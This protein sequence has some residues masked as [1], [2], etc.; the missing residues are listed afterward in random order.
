MGFHSG[1]LS[2]GYLGVDVFFA[3]SGFLITSLLVEEYERNGAISLRKF[4][5]RRALRLLPALVVLIGLC[6]VVLLVAIPPEFWSLA[7]A[8]AAAV[9]FYVANWASIWGMQL[10]VF[11]HTWSLA[12]EEQFY[13]LW[14]LVL[15]GLLRFV[16]N[17]RAI[18]SIVVG[19]AIAAIAYRIVI[20]GMGASLSHLYRGLD[21][22][23]DPLLIGCAAGLFLCWGRLPSSRIALAGAKIVGLVAAVSLTFLFVAAGFPADYVRYQVGAV[24]A[25][26]AVLI[27]VD[28][29][30]ARSWLARGLENPLLVSLGRI[31]YGVYLWHYPIFYAVGALSLNGQ[32]PALP[33][34]IAGCI[35]TLAIATASYQIVERPALEL[36]QRFTALRARP[37]QKANN[38]PI[39]DRASGEV[40]PSFYRH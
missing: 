40:A 36:K 32:V 8:Y 20:A 16:R 10:G 1:R 28:V 17:Q 19:G 11:S 14:P 5:A 6:E 37:S 22:H 7:L 21:A 26:A 18:E 33:R 34:M 9:L 13:L 30:V 24:T 15:I 31:S 25:L 4:Y 35:A 3:L 23:A 12:I 27:I 29:C 39:E 38:S 2:G